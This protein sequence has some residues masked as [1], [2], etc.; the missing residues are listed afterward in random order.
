MA[1]FKNFGIKGTG[2][3]V[4]LGKGNPRIKV[5]GSDI[6]VRNADNTAYVNLS[7][8]DPTAAQHVAT[9]GY[10]DAIAQGLDLKA[11]VRAKTTAN[12]ADLAA[13]APL[14]VDGVTLVA[15]NRVL[16]ASQSTASGNGIYEVVTAGTGVNGAWVR[17]SDANTSA[18][19]TSGMFTFV[20][21][22]T[23]HADQ[24]WALIT[25]DPITLGTTA[26]A[27]TQFSGTGTFTQD[28]LYRQQA[29]TTTA[30]QN[31]GT[32][33][34]ATAKVQRVKL[35]VSTPYS[36]GGTIAIGDGTNTYMTVGEND[37]Q[38]AGTY[39]AEMLTT[40]VVVA[41]QL[42]ATIGGAPAA[43]VAVVHVDYTL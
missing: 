27:F 6:L 40:A 1:D 20:E 41:T 37:A 30:S 9:K 2:D 5:S 29:L 25:N 28:V 17:T 23:I 12:I 39:I 33:V 8:L 36:A 43:G 10:V 42:V 7:A 18:K 21:E 34:P 11:S 26:L 3:D 14:V 32:V 35:T 4:Q 19:V 15:G 22:G 38:I 24:G 16:V 31:V 13:G